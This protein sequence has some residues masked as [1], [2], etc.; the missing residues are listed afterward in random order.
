MFVMPMQPT[1]MVISGIDGDG[2]GNGGTA[3]AAGCGGDDDGGKKGN[4]LCPV[5]RDSYIRAGL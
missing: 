3:A 5:N 4:C 1:M 2:D